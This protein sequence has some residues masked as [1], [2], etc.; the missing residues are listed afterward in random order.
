MFSI[1][2]SGIPD[3][4]NIQ[5][6]PEGSQLYEISGPVFLIF[7][8]FRAFLREANYMKLVVPECGQY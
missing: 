1:F 7:L 8:I 3:F 2:T 5:G 6:I 4:S